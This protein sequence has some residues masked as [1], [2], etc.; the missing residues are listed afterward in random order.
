MTATLAPVPD[1]A[2]LDLAPGRPEVAHIVRPA[3]AVTRAMVD[4][5]PV[6]A[7]C[8]FTWVPTRD[9]EGLPIC[10][11]CQRAKAEILK[12]AA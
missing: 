3:G 2:G 12:A 11:R 10:P 6:T 5:T 1:V 9:P 7:L 8:G 4:G